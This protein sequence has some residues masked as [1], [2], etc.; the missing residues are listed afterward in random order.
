MYHTFFYVIKKAKNVF[1]FFFFQY[2]VIFKYSGDHG[3]GTTLSR[4]IREGKNH[5]RVAQIDARNNRCF[6]FNQNISSAIRKKKL[7]RRNSIL[8]IE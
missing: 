8:G 4:R 5:N 7:S 6:F 1:C 3:V 2:L